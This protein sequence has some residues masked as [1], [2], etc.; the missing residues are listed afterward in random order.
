MEKTFD[1]V[2]SSLS[3]DDLLSK[4]YFEVGLKMALSERSSDVI[5]T[6][7]HK[8][9][10][11]YIG[12]NQ[13][14]LRDVM[15]NGHN[16]RNIHLVSRLCRTFAETISPDQ[17]KQL[18]LIPAF[19]ETFNGD[20]KA[21]LL[22]RVQEVDSLMTEEELHKRHQHL[23]S[24]EHAVVG[25]PLL[26][27]DMDSLGFEGSKAYRQLSVEEMDVVERE[28]LKKELEQKFLQ[29]L[30]A[31]IVPWIHSEAYEAFR[32]KILGQGTVA[33]VVEL[34]LLPEHQRTRLLSRHLSE[35]TVFSEKLG[36]AYH[37]IGV[38]SLMAQMAPL[39]KI[40]STKTSELSGLQEDLSS[41]KHPFINCSWGPCGD[42]KVTNGSFSI[43]SSHKELNDLLGRNDVVLIQAA[44]NEQAVLS[45]PDSTEDISGKVYAALLN[46]VEPEKFVNLIL[47][48]NIKP[49][50]QISDSS[51]M[52]GHQVKIQRNA[53]SAQGCGT[54]WLDET[55]HRHRPLSDGG[56]SS[57]API[58]TGAAVL[59]QSYKPDFSPVLIK[60]CLLHSA[61]REFPVYGDDET[62]KHVVYE[63]SSQKLTDEKYSF[64]K[65][66]MGILNV[67]RA[68]AYADLL[69]GHLKTR[70]EE[71]PMT[72]EEFE[73]LRVK[74]PLRTPG[75]IEKED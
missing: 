17:L 19:W 37:N 54:F 6:L 69:E 71:S 43:F 45:D 36:G 39:A 62:L 32:S 48:I 53:L 34:D 24:Y 74:L 38:T 33:L 23:N 3:L 46:R 7:L 57:A 2:F 65:Y 67:P 73:S 58:I 56:T 28:A 70:T 31:K 50:N 1:H 68:L 15:K 20:L 40:T 14:I 13:D 4:I 29:S 9:I 55:G 22:K 12:G 59:L 26:A 18:I 52:P 60:E 72:F 61:L 64:A 5:E 21:L 66:G 49:N 30:S 47:A 75:R 25:H 16:D 11:G 8:G 41:G 63:S 51:N 44:G 42:L 27:D 35:K 10:L